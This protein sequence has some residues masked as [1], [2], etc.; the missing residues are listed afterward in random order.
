MIKNEFVKFQDK[1]YIVKRILKEDYGPNIDVWKEHLGADLVLK[2]ENLLYFVESVPDLDIIP[3][4]NTL[5]EE[6]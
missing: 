1:L 2:K 6:K 5:K 4:D 3:E